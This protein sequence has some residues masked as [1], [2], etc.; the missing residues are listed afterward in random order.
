MP[1]SQMTSSQYHRHPSRAVRAADGG[2]VFITTY[3]KT[4]HVIVTIDSFDRMT[5]ER[6]EEANAASLTAADEKAIR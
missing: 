6:L 4:T 2:P 3:G 5:A 1:A